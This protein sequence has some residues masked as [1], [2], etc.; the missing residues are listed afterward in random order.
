MRI[1]ILGS[2]GSIGTQTLDVVRGLRA[3][4]HPVRIVGLAARGSTA[5]LA[6]QAREFG[7]PALAVS[8]ASAD[9]A[10]L[11]AG[12]RVFRGAD[13]A[14][15]LV[16]AVDADVVV[17][18]MVGVAGLPATLA[19]IERGGRIALAN[20]ETLV[21]GGGLVTAA[22]AQS[23]AVLMPVDSEHSAVWQCLLGSRCDGA[24][25][26]MPPVAATHP[27]LS[28]VEKIVLTAS[29]GSLR[30]WPRVRLVHATPADA[31]RHPTWTMGAKVT[32]DSASL[33]NKCLELIE[34][35]WLFH[36]PAEKFDAVVHPQSI[37]HALV[38]MRDGSLLAQL[39]TPDMRTPIRLALTG[40][41]RDAPQGPRLDV[42]ALGGLEFRP[43]DA[44][45]YPAIAL[46]R[47]CV[48]ADR[49][50]ATTAGA[51]LNA[52]NEEAVAA[53]LHEK[54]ADGKRLPFPR[55][56]ELARAA[57]EAVRATPLRTISDLRAADSAAREF[58][59]S[60]V[61]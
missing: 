18:A 9:V 38:E 43:V 54:N 22:A 45:R 8:D 23:G 57:L 52:A 17:A 60:A 24:G 15:E 44:E 5:L 25:A 19:A 50:A 41:D 3:G 42:A 37:V 35:F 21:A 20:K 58:V 14:E 59:R 7:A 10:C 49:A 29:G 33:M 31:L 26:A 28:R 46:W 55:I 51:I 30:D 39:G 13:A 11:P 53:F 40:P 56:V 27:A 16:R 61:G 1:I 47:R 4:G 34:A 48:P 6:E 12:A 32:I 2:T 36:L